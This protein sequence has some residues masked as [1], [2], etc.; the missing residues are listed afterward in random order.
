MVPTSLPDLPKPSRTLRKSQKHEFQNPNFQ[1]THRGKILTLL[2]NPF[3]GVCVLPSEDMVRGLTN[4]QCLK[5]HASYQCLQA[6]K[7]IKVQMGHFAP[8]VAPKKA[9]RKFS[10]QQEDIRNYICSQYFLN[11]SVKF[12]VLKL[13][14]VAFSQGPGGFREVQEAGRN[15]FHLS[16]YLLVPGVTSYEQKRD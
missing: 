13:R 16:W 15:H 3:F 5:H 11:F 1:R 12:R 9:N 7:I 8:R 4:A 14:F 10:F 2:I 6:L